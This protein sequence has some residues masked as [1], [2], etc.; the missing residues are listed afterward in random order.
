LYWDIEVTPE[1]EDEMIMKIAHKIHEYGLDVAA[2]LIIESVKPLSYMGTQMGR[3]LLSPFLFV[4]GEDIGIG[5][6]KFFQIFKNHENVEKLI[7]AVEDLTQEEEERKKAEKTKKLDEKRV[8][9]EKEETY[10]K[11]WWQRFLP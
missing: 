6:E 2:I 1:D 9:T 5:G 3:F 10:N 8:K 7:K 4:F 11:K